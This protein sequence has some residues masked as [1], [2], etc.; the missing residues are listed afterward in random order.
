MI[1]FFLNP[2]LF[3]MINIIAIISYFL[4][5]KN[6]YQNSYV[7]FLIISINLLF[8]LIGFKIKNLKKIDKVLS[9]RIRGENFLEILII[10]VNI[11]EYIS[12]GI[13]L[14]GKVVYAFFGFPLLHH[15]AVSSWML[16]F[17]KKNKIKIFSYINPILMLNRDLLLLTI[18][19]I[20]IINIINQKLKLKY[21]F[22]IIVIVLLGFGALGE[23]RSPNA[24]S[25]IK[26]P[27]REYIY[28]LPNILKWPLIYISSSYFNFLFNLNNGSSYLLYSSFI[29]V[30]PEVYKY[31][32]LFNYSGVI[33]FLS[34]VYCVNVLFFLNSYKNKNYL[35]LYIYLI[36]Q[37]IMTLFSSKYFITNTLFTILFLIFFNYIFQ[38]MKFLSNKERKINDNSINSNIS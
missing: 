13:P 27:F 18:F 37:S 36:Y 29:N 35:M 6:D 20:F 4:I 33:V 23:I 32:D 38:F 24:L 10:G 15:I 17:S 3:S 19:S 11:L 16:S 30:F 9:R 26:L 31:Y 28:I 7:I 12:F 34:S 21:I 5:Y 8:V 25:I 14:T 22:P 1:S 2:S